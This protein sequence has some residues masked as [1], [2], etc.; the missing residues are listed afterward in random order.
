LS[1]RRI[2]LLPYHS[3]GNIFCLLENSSFRN[4]LSTLH[5]S[6]ILKHHRRFLTK[7]TFVR[8]SSAMMYLPRSATR[9]IKESGK[10]AILVLYFLLLI[11]FATD[12]VYLKVR[13]HAGILFEG[14]EMLALPRLQLSPR[15]LVVCPR[16]RALTNGHRRQSFNAVCMAWKCLTPPSVLFM[17]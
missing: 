3:A 15:G 1:A 10:G 7:R 13:H 12:I 16:D 14:L 17:R 8:N 2:H 4:H 6:H 9:L 5:L 11:P